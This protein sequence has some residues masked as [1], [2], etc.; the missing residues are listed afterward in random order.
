MLEVEGLSAWYGASHALQ[1]V[2]FGVAEGEILCLLGRNGAGKT[3]TLKAIMGLMPR[4]AGSVRFRGEEVLQRPPEARF[5]LGLAY[6]PEE[7][8]IV[9]GLTVRENLRLGLIAAR[10]RQ[11]EA[12]ALDRIA[13]TF[14]RLRE[15]LDQQASTMS[16]G[17]QQML[18][19]ARAL[20]AEPRLLMLDEPSE[21]IMPVLVDE[22]FD[23]FARL[24][25]DGTTLLLVEQN[26]ELALNLADRAVVLDQ[27]EV[28]HRAA[29][30]ELLADAEV[31]ARYCAV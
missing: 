15:R 6:V 20:M 2:A 30:A 11:D 31:Q 1:S 24:R 5:H 16:G 27:G 17:E 28:V 12:R 10:N 8:R 19:I 18:A 22:M 7:R 9:P 26:V 3:T 21:G 4:R 13:E 23:L 29:A 14:P 25:R